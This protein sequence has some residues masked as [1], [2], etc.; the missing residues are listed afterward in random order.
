[1]C[2][3]FDA[4]GEHIGEGRDKA[5]IDELIEAGLHGLVLCSGTGE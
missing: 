1:M 3:P 4:S 2:T 5:H